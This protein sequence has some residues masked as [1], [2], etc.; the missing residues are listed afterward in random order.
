MKKIGLVGG[1]SWT[2]TLDYYKYINEGVNEALGGLQSAELI[3][4]SLNFADIQDKGWLNSFDLLLKACK[5]LKKN[6]VE[7][8]VLC[9]NTAHLFADEIQEI[10]N[11]PII[12]IIT[13][14][15]Q[16]INSKKIN[17]IG[18]LGTKFTMEMDFYRK[19]LNEHQIEVLIPETLSDIDRIH[20]IVK[21]ELGKGII[22]ESSKKE[23]VKFSEDLIQKGAQGIVLGCTEIPLLIDEKD[24]NSTPVFDT[25]K[26]HV[27][28]ILDFILD[29]N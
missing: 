22:K 15:A 16:E 20:Y 10:I 4:Y 28:A 21:E 9:A 26:I 14:T 29:K 27:Q 5:E 1:I 6:N 8:I 17:K 19:K 13:A 12:N 2:S 18:L 11:I 24:F 25:T 23:F 3:L 7:G